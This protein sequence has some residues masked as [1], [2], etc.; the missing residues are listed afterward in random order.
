MLVPGGWVAGCCAESLVCRVARTML[1]DDELRGR[2]AGAQDARG[3]DVEARHGEAAERALQVVE[4]Q[5]G[6]EHRAERH[7]AGD[8]GEAVE[9][10]KA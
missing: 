7:V 6:I 9:V 8:P 1:V 2:H 4:R 10:Q 5:A 3:A